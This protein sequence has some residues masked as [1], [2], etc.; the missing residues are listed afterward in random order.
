LALKRYAIIKAYFLIPQIKK[1]SKMFLLEVKKIIQL[2]GL[3]R[4]ASFG[5][6]YHKEGIFFSSFYGSV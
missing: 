3:V 5:S 1:I 6:F 2:K 4:V